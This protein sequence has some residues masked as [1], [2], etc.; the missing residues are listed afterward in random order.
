MRRQNRVLRMKQRI[1]IGLVKEDA[2]AWRVE[3]AELLH[4]RSKAGFVIPGKNIAGF[5]L[6]ADLVAF[7]DVRP[8]T[9]GDSHVQRGIV[10]AAVHGMEYQ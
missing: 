7:E 4:Q 3:L 1:V 10:V 2:I 6:V 5:G 9:G 8:F